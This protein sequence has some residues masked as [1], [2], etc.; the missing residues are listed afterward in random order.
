MTFQMVLWAIEEAAA[1]A[2]QCAVDAFGKNVPSAEVAWDFLN[3]QVYG[4]GEVTRPEALP[5]FMPRQFKRGYERHC[6]TL[7]QSNAHTA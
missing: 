3:E 7:L 1:E 6:R 5:E 2:A 4:S